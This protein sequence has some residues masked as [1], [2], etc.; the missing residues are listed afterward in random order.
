MTKCNKGPRVLRKIF[1]EIFFSETCSELLLKKCLLNISFVIALFLDIVGG[2][3]QDQWKKSCYDF[4][5]FYSMQI[6]IV[7]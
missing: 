1:S 4:Y 3:W 6:V 2:G 7:E 5:I